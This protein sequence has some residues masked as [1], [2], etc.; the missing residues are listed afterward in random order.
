MTHSRIAFVLT[1]VTVLSVASG[2]RRGEPTAA[3]LPSD[4]A[5]TV[6][7]Q[8]IRQDELDKAY[9]LMFQASP[10]PASD[11]EAQTQKLSTL[12]E[13]INQ[14]IL[15]ARAKAAKLEATDA[16]VDTAFSER[17]RGLSDDAYQ[18]Q[19][20]ERGLSTDDVK[21]GIRRELTIQKLLDHELISKIVVSDEDVASFYNQNRAQ[22]NLAEPQYRVAEIVVSGSRNPEI[23][24]RLNDDAT[25]PAEAKRKVDMIL[26]RLRGGTEFSTLAMD[27][28][29]D[30]Q[31][32]PQGGDLGFIPVS[33]L[34]Q[35]P[36]ALKDAVMKTEPGNV[37]AATVGDTTILVM[38]AAREPAGQRELNS[39][40]VKDTIKNMLHDRREQLV[41]TA[42]MAAARNDAKV[43]NALATR[44][45]DA[46]VKAPAQP[47]TAPK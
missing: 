44:I 19:L 34:A 18:K 35:A 40:G 30:P 36:A 32:A 12:E 11:A 14:Q 15:L 23:R 10:A 21:R 29:E 28:S 39:P 41:R 20:T 38:V 3:S 1:V 37:S 8:Q 16:E 4:V 5:A 25:T 17:R 27:Y 33:G 2:C 47:A 45:V 24:N 43:V 26:E 13:L 6:D 31:S 22:F 46:Q 42:Y 9:R 7:G